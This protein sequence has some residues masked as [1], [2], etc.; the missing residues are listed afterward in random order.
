MIE[1]IDNALDEPIFK[2]ITDIVISDKGNFPWYLVK[3]I[4]DINKFPN[5]IQT[6]QLT[7][8]LFS[9]IK[10]YNGGYSLEDKSP[11]TRFIH[12]LIIPVLK[13][14]KIYGDIVKSKFNLLFPH[15]KIKNN[16]DHNVT[17]IDLGEPHYSILLYLNDSDGD[18][19]FFKDKGNIELKRITPKS[20]RM[21]ISNGLYHT[22]TNPIKFN[23]RAVLNIVVRKN[24]EI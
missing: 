5:G 6:Y 20:N 9:N 4:Y 14:N 8:H 7:H 1:V 22:S 19:V 2:S 18:T 12:K 10:E 13:K 24:N 23:F 17:H 11:H 16:L 21:I 15:P 3:D